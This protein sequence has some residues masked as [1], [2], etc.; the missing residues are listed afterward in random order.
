MTL[1]RA[2][3]IDNQ[4][5]YNFCGFSRSGIEIGEKMEIIFL[6][7]LHLLQTPFIDRLPPP[8]DVPLPAKA[9][10]FPVSDV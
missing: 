5:N 10:H 6:L 7:G 4:G 1:R 3:E 2:Y 8:A 9:L